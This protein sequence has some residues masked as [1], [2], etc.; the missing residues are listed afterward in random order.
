M[1]PIFFAPRSLFVLGM[2]WHDHHHAFL[3]SDERRQKLNIQIYFSCVLSCTNSRVTSSLLL[4]LHPNAAFSLPCV[5]PTN[6]QRPPCAAMV[7]P[8]YKTAPRAAPS[9][10][11]SA[12]ALGAAASRGRAAPPTAA[13]RQC[14]RTTLPA[15]R[16]HASSPT[17]PLLRPG[18]PG[19]SLHTVSVLALYRVVLCC[20]LLYCVVLC[21]IVL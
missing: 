11:V 17:S 3:K 2:V 15:A 10:A 7:L 21:C 20:N 12:G 1:A 16:P 8:V 4:P 6:H 18:I 13:R 19:R 9:P 14:W 5:L